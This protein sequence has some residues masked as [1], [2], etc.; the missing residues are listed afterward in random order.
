MFYSIFW[1]VDVLFI[2][3]SMMYFQASFGR[4]LLST[5]RGHGGSYACYSFTFNPLVHCFPPPSPTTRD[6][7]PIPA[8]ETKERNKEN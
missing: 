3:S 6:R 7:W 5:Y 4:W 8:H 1:Y 2:G